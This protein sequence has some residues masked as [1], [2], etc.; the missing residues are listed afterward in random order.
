LLL[1]NAFQLYLNDLVTSLT[2]F[3]LSRQINHPLQSIESVNQTLHNTQLI[4]IETHRTIPFP[5]P[6]NL[7]MSEF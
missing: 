5:F 1:A 4:Y 6:F 3:E 2:I 7:H